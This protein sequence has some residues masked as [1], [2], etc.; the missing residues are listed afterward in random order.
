MTHI[1]IGKVRSEFI[2][3][4]CVLPLNSNLSIFA[5]FT[6]TSVGSL[7]RFFCNIEIYLFEIFLATWITLFSEAVQIN[8][9]RSLS[10]LA[11]RRAAHSRTGSLCAK[12]F[13][14]LLKML[15]FLVILC[16]LLTACRSS[17]C[18]CE[19]PELCQQIR[20]EKDFEVNLVD[21]S[22]AAKTWPKK[23]KNL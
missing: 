2:I 16:S 14:F 8:D 12:T 19:R 4:R 18:P 20:E 7:A 21:Q 22:V 9:S 15:S 17:V 10:H 13:L 5:W 1:I 23:T 6:L 3:W 11:R